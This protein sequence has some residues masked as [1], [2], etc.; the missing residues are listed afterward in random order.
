LNDPKTS[1]EKK[2]EL[3]CRLKDFISRYSEIVQFAQYATDT[4]VRPTVDYQPAI[5]FSDYFKNRYPA[6]NPAIA[7]QNENNQQ[8]PGKHQGSFGAVKEAE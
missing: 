1:P 5:T 2:L 4:N 3:Q 8:G 7:I 6:D